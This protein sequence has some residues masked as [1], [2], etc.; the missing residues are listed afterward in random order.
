MGNL[1]MTNYEVRDFDKKIMEFAEE[2]DIEGLENYIFDI[3]K[4][5]EIGADFARKYENM[6]IVLGEPVLVS[7]AFPSS[8]IKGWSIR[9]GIQPFY[10]KVK[11]DGVVYQ[12]SINM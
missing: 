7:N 3:L 6:M 9:N 12:R 2:K 10:Y 11:V 1:T 8:K 5:K 4:D